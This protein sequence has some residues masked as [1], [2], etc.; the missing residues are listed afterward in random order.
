[1]VVGSL[2]GRRA[3]PGDAPYAI[4]KTALTGLV[5]VLRQ[6]LRPFGIGVTGVYPGRIDTAIIADLRVPRISRKVPPERVATAIVCAVERGRP[7]VVVP[8]SGRLL[9]YADL[10]SPRMT[11]WMIGRLGLSG[12]REGTE[13]G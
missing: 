11:E 1:M 5:Q 12:R 8:R 4:A 10:V 3:L 2:D 7:E 9:L 6:E 13:R